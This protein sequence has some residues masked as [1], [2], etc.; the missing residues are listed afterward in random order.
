MVECSPCRACYFSTAG[1]PVKNDIIEDD[2][3]AGQRFELELATSGYRVNGYLVIVLEDAE[4][5]RAWTSAIDMQVKI[6]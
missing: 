6:T 5:N 2:A 4:G 1:W 3:P